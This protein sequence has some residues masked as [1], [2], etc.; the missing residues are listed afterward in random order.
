MERL[1]LEREGCDGLIFNGVLPSGEIN[2]SFQTDEILLNELEIYLDL[3]FKDKLVDVIFRPVKDMNNLDEQI[4]LE[5][6]KNLVF[7]LTNR[8]DKFIIDL[9]SIDGLQ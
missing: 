3:G 9:Q 4:S 1:F 6:A 5:M 2:K 7:E 8:V